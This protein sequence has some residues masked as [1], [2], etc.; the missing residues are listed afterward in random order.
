MQ[1][2]AA[3]T[4]AARALAW[5]TGQDGLLSVFLGA[6]GLNVSDVAAQAEEPEFLASVL[7]FV[8]MDDEW[9]RGFCDAAQ[10]PYDLPMKA[11]AAL[12]GGGEVHWT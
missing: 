7:D 10:M 6:S 9:V 4:L 3:E 2:D 8:L 5:L 1:Q 12:P 11:R